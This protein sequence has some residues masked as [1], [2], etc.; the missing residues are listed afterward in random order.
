MN[1]TQKFWDKALVNIVLFANFCS[2]LFPNVIHAKSRLLQLFRIHFRLFDDAVYQRHLI[3]KYIFMK[4]QEEPIFCI[5][6]WGNNV[7]RM[8]TSFSRHINLTLDCPD[9]FVFPRRDDNN[10]RCGGYGLLGC[11]H[12]Y[13]LRCALDYFGDVITANTHNDVFTWKRIPY[14]WPIAS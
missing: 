6:M 11:E 4:S 8:A 9:S 10:F 5:H 12:Q 13:Y 3:R 2:D 14:C 1:K 7:V